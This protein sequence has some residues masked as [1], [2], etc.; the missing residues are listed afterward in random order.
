MVNF[1]LMREL[2][3]SSGEK[4]FEKVTLCYNFFYQIANASDMQLHI[5]RQ[6]VDLMSSYDDRTTDTIKKNT[7]NVSKPKKKSFIYGI[8]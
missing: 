6:E 3:F 2:V 7:Q 5:W 1:C 8:N 4:S